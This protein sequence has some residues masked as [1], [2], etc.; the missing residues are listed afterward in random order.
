MSDSWRSILERAAD[1]LS[2]DLDQMAVPAFSHAQAAPLGHRRLSP[3]LS[4][5][6]SR[7]LLAREL[8]AF[9]APSRPAQVRVEASTAL[10]VPV[11]APTQKSQPAPRTPRKRTPWQNVLATL[12][13]AI[14]TGGLTA[15]FL[16]AQ[17][18]L[19]KEDV[20]AFAAYADQAFH[21]ASEEDGNAASNA[22]ASAAAAVSRSTEDA[23]MERASYQLSHGDGQGGRAVFEVLAH[24]GSVR[25][26]FALAETYDP[27]AVAQH[28][29][30]GLKS[31]VRLAREWYMKASELGSLSAYE[32]L[33]SLDKRAASLQ[34]RAA[35]L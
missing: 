29:D 7:E 14:L 9:S 25:G 8:Q 11:T 16:L 28:A 22:S 4:F 34:R 5:A 23:L 3:Q 6:E 20:L 33:K 35:Q 24:H 27:G 2:I 26:A 31:D 10:T 12:L 17:G 19:G 32:R 21:S 18:G 30:W 1:N 15:Y 13:S